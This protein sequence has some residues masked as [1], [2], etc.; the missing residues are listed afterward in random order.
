MEYE[1]WRAR[2][3]IDGF[4]EACSNIVTSYLK[5]GYESMSSLQFCTTSKGDLPQ[6]SYVFRKPGPLGTELNTVSCFATG[7]LILL[8]IQRGEEGMKSIWF[9]LE[10]GNTATCAKILMERTKMDGEEGLE[11]INGGFTPV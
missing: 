8:K 4:N 1:W 9:H 5:V 3:L 7:D 6:L 10:L 11:R 2:L